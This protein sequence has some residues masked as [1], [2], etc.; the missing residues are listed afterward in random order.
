MRESKSEASTITHESSTVSWRSRI[1]SAVAAL[2]GVGA[3]IA[4]VAALLTLDPGRASQRP[5][6]SITLTTLG[7]ATDLFNDPTV[8]LTGYLQAAAIVLLILFAAQL[9]S[10]VGSSDG[11]HPSAS[12]FVA[13]LITMISAVYAVEWGMAFALA[14]AGLER[15]D[16]MSL[17]SY[18]VWTSWMYRI[19]AVAFIAAMVTIAVCGLHRIAVPP[20]ARVGSGVLAVI[21]AFATF[22]GQWG[23]MF[24]T[25]LAW[26]AAI[27]GGMVLYAILPSSAGHS[28]NHPNGTN[29]VPPMP[30]ES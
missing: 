14:E 27:S 8:Q 1:I 24:L 26:V 10:R 16:A 9:A 29:R 19:G 6:P 23:F 30:S 21:L 7:P 15:D 18:F 20:L 17:F 12:T 5:L 4:L 13:A 2:A 3:S 22:G 11:S 25:G 28:E